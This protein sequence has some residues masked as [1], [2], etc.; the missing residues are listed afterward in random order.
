MTSS[1]SLPIFFGPSKAPKLSGF[2]EAVAVARADA[3]ASIK[4]ASDQLDDV[5]G[6]YVTSNR[7]TRFAAE[8]FHKEGRSDLWFFATM[9]PIFL[10][11]SVCAGLVL[12]LP[13]WPLTGGVAATIGLFFTYEALVTVLLGEKRCVE[14]AAA[15]AAQPWGIGNKAIYIAEKGKVRVVRMDSVGSIAIEDNKVVVSS[16]FGEPTVSFKYPM[17]DRSLDEVVADIRKRIP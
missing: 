16:R 4:T 8:F 3:V 2:E 12:P 11:V 17:T 13:L 5:V 10:I 1:I 9:G 15:Y 14:R 7:A 6:E